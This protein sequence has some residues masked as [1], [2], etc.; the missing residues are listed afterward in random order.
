L[1]RRPESLELAHDQANKSM[2]IRTT[3]L[4]TQNVDH[5]DGGADGERS[6]ATVGHP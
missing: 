1:T 4:A 2:G 5:G 3:R 6:T